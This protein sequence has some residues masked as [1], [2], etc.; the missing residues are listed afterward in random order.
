[1]HYILLSFSHKNTDLTTREKLSF[2]KKKQIEIL[3]KLTD[4]DCISEAIVLSTCNRLEVIANANNNTRSISKVFETL[5]IFS[6]IN[7]NE[8]EGRADIFEDEGAVK[9]LFSVAAALESLVVGE[10]QIIGQL[11]DSYNLAKENKFCGAKIS[12]LVEFSFR[13]AAE[14]KSATNIG[15][16]PVSVASAAVAQAKDALGSLEGYTA[17]VFGTGDMGVLTTK[18]LVGNGAS[19]IMVGRDLANTEKIAAEISDKVRAEP[20]SNITNLINSHVLFFT[21][22]G[23]PVALITNDMII[24]RD[25][26]RYWFDLAVPRDINIKENSRITVYEVDDLKAI[27]KK[28]MSLRE[29]ET[30][31]AFK[32]VGEYTNNFYKWLETLSVDPIIKELRISA[33]NIAKAE[34][35][36]AIN[37]GYIPKEHEKAVSAILHN[38]FKAFLHKPTTAIKNIADKPEADYFIEVVKQMFNVEEDRIKLI[39]KEN[40]EQEK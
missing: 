24:E 13:C 2:D 10:N 36:K 39:S 1:M 40:K 33:Q 22:T 34:L 30:S 27:V 18:H 9:H 7:K 25:F 3:E 15:K 21:A 12:R 17:I 29:D 32:I 5:N 26:H 35:E 31:K 28:N 8:L 20:Y 19:V 38:S 6:G 14:I 11:K 16:N 23:A 37:K 4:C